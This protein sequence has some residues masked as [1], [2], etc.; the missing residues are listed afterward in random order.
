VDDSIGS[1]RKRD[2]YLAV[3]DASLTTARREDFRIVHASVQGD[4]IHLIV[5]AQ[6]KDAIS[7]GMRGFEI[8]AA[9]RINNA[10]TKRTGRRRRGAVFPDRY[11]MRVLTSPRAVKHALAYVLN[12]WRKHGEDRHGLPS[13]WKIDPFS[14]G[15]RFGGWRELEGS[16]TLFRAPATYQALWVWLPKTWLLREGWTRH[17]LISTHDVPGP[18]R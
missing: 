8:S 4:H 14:S 6:D 1:L 7:R 12:N 11:H 15:V 13:T 5:E 3:R 18:Q 10:V 17:G 9:M 16:P 2:M